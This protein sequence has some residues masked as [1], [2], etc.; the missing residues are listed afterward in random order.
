MC[1][2]YRMNILICSNECCKPSV[3]L[4]PSKSINTFWLEHP[5]QPKTAI[6]AELTQVGHKALFIWRIVQETSHTLCLVMLVMQILHILPVSV[7]CLLFFFVPVSVSKPQWIL[8]VSEHQMPW[9]NNTAHRCLK[10]R[11]LDPIS[12]WGKLLIHAAQPLFTVSLIDES[13][14]LGRE[15]SILIYPL[16]HGLRTWLSTGENRKR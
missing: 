4:F 11:W 2:I 9:A 16:R 1:T 12:P 15:T 7:F 8:G 6:L 13:H 10:S 14:E 3:G 5:D